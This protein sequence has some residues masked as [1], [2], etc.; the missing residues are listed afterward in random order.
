ML[1]KIDHQSRNHLHN[2]TFRIIRWPELKTI[3][4]LARTTVWRREK[5]GRFPKKVDLGGGLIGWRSDEVEEWLMN[6][7]GY[8]APRDK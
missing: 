3:T 2:C 1:H 8:I 7:A 4:G 5:L 6:P